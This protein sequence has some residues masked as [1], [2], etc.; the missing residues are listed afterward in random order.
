VRWLPDSQT[1][2]FSQIVYG[3]SGDGVQSY[4]MGAKK[5]GLVAEKGRHA[6]YALSPDGG[7]ALVVPA[8]NPEIKGTNQR[9][10]GLQAAGGL[11]PFIIGINPFSGDPI[12]MK[13][14]LLHGQLDQP[15]F[16]NDYR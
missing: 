2:L 3:E 4:N 15:T 16:K 1:V 6:T 9:D 14:G 11:Q 8:Q 7:K 10:L 12:R 5:T 13:K